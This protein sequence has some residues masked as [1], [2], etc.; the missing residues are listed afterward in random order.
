MMIY[1]V[2]R[3]RNPMIKMYALLPRRPDVSVERFHEHWRTVHRE[4]ALKIDR[5]R[6][7]TQAHRIRPGLPGV[8]EAPWDGVPEV[9]FDDRASALAQRSDPQ[10]V[11]H[12]HRDEP[13]FVDV[14][15]IR[16]LLAEHRVVGG[17]GD[18]KTKMMLF[19]RRAPALDP[20]AFA[21][22]WWALGE[23]LATP[24]RATGV[25][26][27]VALSHPAPAYDA[28]AEL[29]WPDEAAARAGWAGA[30]SPAGALDTVVDPAATVGFFC[31]E[32]RVR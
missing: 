28:V 31:S 12:A 21:A 4:H 19:V 8:P 30:S 15:R 5:I 13:N 32:L 3:P 10:Y 26:L 16:R 20:A 6:R 25:A 22:A 1:R 29:S 9:W 11:E 2:R 24:V 7:Y 18:G 27:A 23:T 14:P 17:L